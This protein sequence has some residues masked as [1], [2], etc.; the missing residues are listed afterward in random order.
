MIRAV[1]DANVFVSAVLSP[2]GIPAKVLKAWHAEQFHLVISEAILEEIGRFFI[3]RRSS[4]ATSGRG[5]RFGRSSKQEG[6][7]SAENQST[8][9]QFRH[10]IQLSEALA[11]MLHP[12]PPVSGFWQFIQESTSLIIKPVRASLEALGSRLALMRRWLVSHDLLRIAGF[13]Y[14]EDPYTELMAWALRPDTHPESAV[15]RQ[16]AWLRGFPFGTGL[17]FERP[18]TPR[19]QVRTEDGIPDLILEYETFVVITE[20]KT[21]SE[22]HLAPSGTPQTLA[23]PDS[24]RRELGLD[25]SK[26]V[27]MVFITPDRR[28]A[29]NP[30]AFNTT[31]AEFAL[32]LASALEAIPLPE[33]VRWAYAMLFTHFFRCALPPETDP[34]AVIKNVDEWLNHLDDDAFLIDRLNEIMGAIRLFSPG[35]F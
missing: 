20:A 19:T 17:H 30:E 28:K 1:L 22:E 23:Y 18:A 24:V 29:S 16:L 8:I 4:S 10:F 33:D 14:A 35:A 3:I 34:F 9:D 26:S 32:S 21:G 7:M 6:L 11:S 27:Y 2:K 13:T 25:E 12:A 31:F 5:R 15:Q